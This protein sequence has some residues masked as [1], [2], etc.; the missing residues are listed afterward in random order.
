MT[1]AVL[2]DFLRPAAPRENPFRAAWER[3]LRRSA[4]RAAARHLAGLDARLLADMGLDP[5]AIR[6]R[7]GWDEIMP[8]G[9][10]VHQR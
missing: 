3:H 1:T 4:E 9:Y 10:L 2:T 5:D 7:D 8:N 6:R